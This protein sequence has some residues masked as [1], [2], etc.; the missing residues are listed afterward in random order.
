MD[1][2]VVIYMTSLR[3]LCYIGYNVFVYEQLRILYSYFS[4]NNI[5]YLNE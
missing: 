4:D 2:D 3:H 5:L 1:I